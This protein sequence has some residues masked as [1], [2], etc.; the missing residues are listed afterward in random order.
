MKLI[1]NWKNVLVKSSSIKIIT[2]AGALLGVSEIIPEDV[3]NGLLQDGSPWAAMGLMVV[4]VIA[5]LV[6]QESISGKD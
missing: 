6:K 3:Y 2:L 4:A 1:K 5:R